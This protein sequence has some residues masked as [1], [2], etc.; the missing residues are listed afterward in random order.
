MTGFEAANADAV[1]LAVVV[2]AK[3]GDV[4]HLLAVDLDPCPGVASRAH[5]RRF[6]PPSTALHGAAPIPHVLGQLTELPFSIGLAAIEV[7]RVD[8]GSLHGLTVAP[9]AT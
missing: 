1:L 2:V 4:A 9:G 5:M 8:A 7:H 3:R 6:G